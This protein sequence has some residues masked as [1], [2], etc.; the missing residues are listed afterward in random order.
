MKIC[1]YENNDFKIL[2][3][4]VPARDVFTNADSMHEFG[5]FPKGLDPE[6]G[7]SV[8]NRGTFDPSD[9]TTSFWPRTPISVGVGLL[10]SMAGA[11]TVLVLSRWLVGHR[12]AG[13]MS[14]LGRR[15]MPIFLAHILATAG[16]R[17]LLGVVGVENVATHLVL[18]IGAGLAFPLV[19]WR[20]GQVTGR[21]WLFEAPR[22][23]RTRRRV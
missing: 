22:A 11:S 4:K 9:P 7:K 13:L 10:T 18:G 23:F 8:Y 2:S 19:L 12:G 1:K 20:L 17:I 16:V 6:V 21:Q 5:Y 15:S 3:K 14:L